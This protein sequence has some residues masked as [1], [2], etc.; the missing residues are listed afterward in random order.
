[1]TLE[2]TVYRQIAKADG[3]QELEDADGQPYIADPNGEPVP[4]GWTQYVYFEPS[5][6]A[7]I[8]PGH[9]AG[10]DGDG[11]YSFV[12]REDEFEMN[13]PNVSFW[14]AHLRRM[15]RDFKID[16]GVFHEY[17]AVGASD[18]LMGHSAAAQLASAFATHQASAEA[19]AADMVDRG[20][21]FLK[22]YNGWRRIF[23]M[24]AENGAVSFH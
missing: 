19:Y 5:C 24:A 8:H 9:L 11:V 20:D 22:R 18:G 6:W 17:L 4:D 14:N 13:Y 12:E 16:E 15:C 1:M 3:Y 10:F 21:Y 23:E 2:V 7:E